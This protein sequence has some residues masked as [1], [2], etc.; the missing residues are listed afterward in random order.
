MDYCFKLHSQNAHLVS[1]SPIISRLES[2]KPTEPI[3]PIRKW[4]NQTGSV[5]RLNRLIENIRLGSAVHSSRASYVKYRKRRSEIVDDFVS[6]PRGIWV[7]LGVQEMA[8]KRSVLR[9]WLFL[10]CLSRCFRSSCGASVR[11]K[12]LQRLYWEVLECQW[13]KTVSNVQTHIC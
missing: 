5:N 11:P 1:M 7:N 3:S 8:S 12:F 13:L 4:I 2:L 9:C 6:M 10:C